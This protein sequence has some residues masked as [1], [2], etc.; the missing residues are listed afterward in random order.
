MISNKYYQSFGLFLLGILLCIPNCRKIISQ[1]F[2]EESVNLPV[3]DGLRSLS[4]TG[5]VCKGDAE[6]EIKKIAFHYKKNPARYSNLSSQDR[7]RNLQFT[8]LLDKENLLND[9]RDSL[10][11]FEGGDCTISSEFIR[12]EARLASEN[13]IIFSFSATILSAKGEKIKSSGKLE[14]KLG[15][16]IVFNETISG[17]G[18]YW[19]EFRIP[20]TGNTAKLLISEMKP[21]WSFR[22]IPAEKDS[23]AFIGEPLLFSKVSS[24]GDWGPKEN[25]I[26]IVVDA[27]RQDRLGYGGSPV[28]TSPVLDRLASQSIVFE[29]AFANGNWTKPSMLSFFTSKIASELGM[30]NAWFYSTNLH[31][32]IFYSKNPETLVNHLRSVGF[33]TA[34]L[35]NNVFLLDYTGVGVDLGFHRL[36]QPGKDKADT[37]L[38]LKESLK[39]LRE[40]K[41]RRFFLHININTPHYPYLPERKYLEALEKSVPAEIW[42]QYDPYVRKYMAE[43]LYT[44]EVIGKILDEAKRTGVYDKTWIAVVADHGELQEMEHY[45]HHHFVAENLHAHG[46]SHYDEEIRVPWILHPPESSKSRI[47]KWKFERQVSL[48]S[49]FPTLV[50][51]MGFPCPESACAGSDYSL[52]IFG[53]KG[54]DFEEVVYTEGRFSES[55]RTEELKLIRRYPG[56]E[57]VRRTREGAPHSMPEELYDLVSDPHEIRNLAPEK[58]R[59]LDKARALLA[60][61]SLKKNSFVLKLPASDKASVRK[62]DLFVDG[63]IY[64]FYSD[65]SFE[66]LRSEHR[67]LSLKVSQAPGKEVIL[68]IDTVEP[69]FRFRLSLWKDGQLENYK[70]GKW[71]FSQEAG[72]QVYAI[73]PETVASSKLPYEFRSST[74]PY[75]YNDAG[76]SGNSDSPDQ[77]ALGKEVRKVLESW[78]YIH[79]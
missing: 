79:E 20:L 10:F 61:N 69:T 44:D 34:S 32:K 39:F 56:Y 31:R 21:N 17:Q 53:E 15:N 47:R 26:L 51:A 73:S 19:E 63:G 62:I 50:G 42:K 49:L 59:M 14:I 40:N 4:K 41:D 66:T 28:P 27:L 52:A 54:R 68:R 71:G 45:Y 13:G 12:K 55:I 11:L 25:L 1:P 76:L 57:I 5:S 29:K 46:E 43:I 72:N 35:M 8:I 64:R 77:A 78:G 37:E 18:D 67:N 33:V 22:W 16:E 3:W 65:S 6:N 23:F 2:G 30:G 70:S 7:W 74:V 48:L 58:S 60:S 38:I 36:F 24:P 75:I 9:S